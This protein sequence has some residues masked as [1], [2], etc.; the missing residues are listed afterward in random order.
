M[1]A[2]NDGSVNAVPGKQLMSHGDEASRAGTGDG[3]FLDSYRSLDVGGLTRVLEEQL[4]T[5]ADLIRS[6]REL[7]EAIDRNGPAI[8]SVS[9]I[10]EVFPEDD[11]GDRHGLLGGI[12][13]LVKDCI[14][15]TDGLLSTCGSLALKDVRPYHQA[16]VVD[17]LLRAGAR[18][19]GKTNLSEWGNFRSNHGVSGWSAYGGLTRNPH[20]LDRSPGGSS[21]GSAAAVAA[22]LVP[23][24]IGTETHG[25]VICPSAACGVVGV[26][27]TVGLISG[28]GVQPVGPSQDTVGVIARCVR[29]A[30]LALAVV[31]A[32]DRGSP[33]DYLLAVEQGVH[34]LRIGVARTTSWGR[35]SGLDA[36]AER[37]LSGLSARGAEIVDDADIPTAQELAGA[38]E[39]AEGQLLLSEFVP[40]VE[41]FLRRRDGGPK[42]LAELVA[43]NAREPAELRW[44]GQEMFE[45]ALQADPVGSDA[46]RAAAAELA[47]LSRH[48]GIDLAMANSQADVLVAPTMPPAWKTDLVNG[49]PDGFASAAAAPAIAGYP[50]VTVPLG[51]VEF[52]P[53]GITIMGSAWSEATLLRVA[54]AVEDVMGRCPAPEFR[55]P[56]PG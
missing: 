43:F 45:A 25:S 6:F 56:S 24:A 2:V 1:S 46:Y 4:A 53:V 15:T 16:T 50:A 27:T 49:D 26:K 33:S 54:G 3:R 13:V 52:L 32:P 55:P 21:S 48:E 29:D 9:Q 38:W 8:N 10:R 31:T 37:A 22:G 42:T 28:D 18:I 36:L 47:R 17:Q 30:A 51:L 14:D 20:A 23:V 39:G 40:A 12:P 19:V 34:G 11:D 7:H 41:S 5:P 44:F 35:H